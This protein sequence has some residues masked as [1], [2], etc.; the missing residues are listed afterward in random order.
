M[1]L[2]ARIQTRGRVTLPAEVR[3]ALQVAGGDELVFVETAPGR[4]EVKAEARGA[5]LLKRR[6][7]ARLEVPV[8]RQLDLL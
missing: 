1:K 5:A 6:R 8:K 2:T 4:Y 7:T 3:R